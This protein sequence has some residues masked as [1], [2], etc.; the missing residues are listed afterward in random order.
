MASTVMST[1]S[2]IAT[3]FSYIGIRI[4][5]R[6]CKI[7]WVPSSVSILSKFPG[8]GIRSGIP[9]LITV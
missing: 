5:P 9:T 8:D 2:R 3:L 4:M 7:S 6:D 1:G